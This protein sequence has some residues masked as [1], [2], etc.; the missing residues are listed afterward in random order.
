M[1]FTGHAYLPTSNDTSRDYTPLITHTKD[2]YV[3]T[4]D[5]GP[6][7]RVST[8]ARFRHS[9]DEQVAIH[10]PLTAFPVVKT[11]TWLLINS[12]VLPFALCDTCF[13]T[14]NTHTPAAAARQPESRV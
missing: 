9:T 1:K 11:T 8:S 7:A 13:Q 6:R 5:R 12:T 2:T 14:F 10:R 3:R 4:I